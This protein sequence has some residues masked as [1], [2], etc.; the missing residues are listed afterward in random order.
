MESGLSEGR[1]RARRVQYGRQSRAALRV[2]GQSIERGMRTMVARINLYEMENGK[3]KVGRLR[4]QTTL[5]NLRCRRADDDDVIGNSIRSGWV[6]TVETTPSPGC[7]RDGSRTLRNRCWLRETA[8]MNVSGYRNMFLARVTRWSE[9]RESTASWI[10]SVVDHD[11]HRASSR[12]V[13]RHHR[14]FC[15]PQ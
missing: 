5:K 12:P 10:P 7:K 13:P 8:A 6:Y 1:R 2:H 9:A 4:R 15:G 3:W 14:P 11:P